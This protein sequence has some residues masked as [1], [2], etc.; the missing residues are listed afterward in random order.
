M[1]VAFLGRA[2]PHLLQLVH[3][4][5]H[6]S[7]PGLMSLSSACWCGKAA[8]WVKDTAQTTRRA[9]CSCVCDECALPPAELQA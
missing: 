9:N 2:Q 7:L 6:S 4:E 1:G 8:V 5:A 3:S